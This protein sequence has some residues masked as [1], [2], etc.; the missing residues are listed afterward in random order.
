MNFETETCSRCH[1]SGS[2]SRCEMYGTTCFRCHGRKL[3]L[4]A[5]GAAAKAYFEALCSKPASEVRVGDAVWFEGF[6]KSCWFEVTEIATGQESGRAW[7]GGVELP[8][9]FDMINIS[10]AEHGINGV[11]PDTIVRVRQSPEQRATN[12]AAAL[13]YQATLTVKGTPRKRSAKAAV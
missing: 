9:R 5:R 12:L 4:T 1:G 7:V 3:T 13:A 10:G 6:S 11:S 2:Y 8:R